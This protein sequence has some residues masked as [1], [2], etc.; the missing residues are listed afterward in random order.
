MPEFQVCWDPNE[1]EQSVYG[2]LQDRHGPLEVMKV[3]ARHRGDLGLDYYSLAKQVVYQCYAVQEPCE[4]EDRAKKQKAKI[5]TDLGK[6]S[7]RGT[8]LTE[9]FGE[10]QIRRWVLTVPLHDSV[11]VNKHLTKKTADIKKLNLT[12]VTSDFQVLAHDLDSFD[13][14]SRERRLLELSLIRVYTSTPTT[15]EVIDWQTGF[16]E[17]S[18]NLTDKLAKRQGIN[19]SNSLERA[20]NH[21]ITWFLEREN[22]LE[23]LRLAAPELHEKIMSIISRHTSRLEVSGPPSEGS[24]NVILRAEVESFTKELMQEIPNFARTNAEQV[25]MGTIAEWLLRCP[26]DFPPYRHVS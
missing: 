23:S 20:V 15:Q 21:A 12:Y 26:L 18:Q 11:Q 13:S 2:L 7:S 6:F 19:G 8:E 9:L 16:S 17:L 1:W 3:P 5:T 22:I 4:V 14:A 10:V 25:A 24:A